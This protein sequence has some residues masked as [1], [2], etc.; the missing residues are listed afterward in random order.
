MWTKSCTKTF[1]GV[2]KEQIWKLWSDV[3]QWHLWDPDIE[4]ATLE[5]EFKAG[6]FFVLKPKGWKPVRIQLTE[7]V[8]NK[9]FTDCTKFFGATMYGCHEMEDTKN[10]L[11]LTTTMTVSGPLTFLWVRL[12]AQGIVNTLPNQMNALVTLA[13]KNKK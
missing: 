3:N 7:V 5:G 12:V 2:K 9:T 11:K 6:S 13:K 4:S 1:K 10:G 8:K